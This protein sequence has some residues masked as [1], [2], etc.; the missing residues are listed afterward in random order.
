MR[1]RQTRIIIGILVG[2]VLFSSSVALLMYSKQ[3][4]LGKYVENHIDVYVASRAIHKG[5]QIGK[6]DLTKASLPKSYLAFAPLMSSEI[7]GKY[8]QVEIFTKEPFRREKIG[9]SK[10]VMEENA[11][12]RVMKSVVKKEI[13]PDKTAKALKKDT[14]TVSLTA[15]KN[16]DS[17]L[18]SGD[19]IDILSVVPKVS[20]N[21]G[22]E[23]TAK[24][25]ALRVT[26]ASFVTNSKNVRKYIVKNSENGVVK[27]DSVV[28]EM[29]PREIKNFL[30]LYYKTL[31]L[32]GNRVFVNK[33]MNNGQLWMVKC[34][35]TED[36]KDSKMKEKMLLDHKS[37]Y[38]ARK[39]KSKPKVSIS[40]ED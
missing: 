24:Y 39:R 13:T 1:N 20:K 9:A 38:K 11:V 35:N 31:E 22:H 10:P 36:E 14:I 21:N 12:P 18:K 8:A 3:N 4:D 16:I 5:E 28:F 6:N 25:I 2:L 19:K 40:Y 30:S 29:T 17:S 15:F 27:A 26:I 34:S 23:F 7:I 33:N 32:N 37:V